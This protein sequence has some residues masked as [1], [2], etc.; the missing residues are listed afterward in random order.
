MANHNILEEARNNKNKGKEYEN[1]ES[2][3]SNLLAFAAA[4]II[5]IVLFLVEYFAKNSVNVSLIAMVMTAACVQSLYEGIK[6]KKKYLIVIGCV[7]ALI[8]IFA[9]LI[10]FTKVVS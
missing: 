1:K 10:F 7:Q 4:I 9:I 3:R 5:G 6:T 2:M 8:V